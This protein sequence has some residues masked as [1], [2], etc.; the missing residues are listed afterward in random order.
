MATGLGSAGYG[1]SSSSSQVQG[2]RGALS[3]PQDPL[4]PDLVTAL[5]SSIALRKGY[6]E[7]QD[8]YRKLEKDRI[9][10]SED[11]DSLIGVL[12]VTKRERD[13]YHDKA[14]TLATEAEYHKDQVTLCERRIDELEY[15]HDWATRQNAHLA[16][17]AVTGNMSLASETERFNKELE[18]YR[19]RLT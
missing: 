4:I 13:E 5:D 12:N 7:L 18:S 16:D 1:G 14:V 19:Q 10:L 6:D 17:R 2:A 3:G 15:K 9:K 11:R 8:A